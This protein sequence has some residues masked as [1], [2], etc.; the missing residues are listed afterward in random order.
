[1]EDKTLLSRKEKVANALPWLPVSCSSPSSWIKTPLWNLF[2]WKQSEDLH[3]RRIKLVKH[4]LFTKGET[5]EK[6]ALKG[7][8]LQC[9]A[10]FSLFFLLLL[11]ED[12]F[13]SH[14]SF[15][16]I[17]FPFYFPSLLSSLSRLWN[18]TSGHLTGQKKS[19]LKTVSANKPQ[20]NRDELKGLYRL[21]RQIKNKSICNGSDTHWFTLTKSNTANYVLC[22]GFIGLRS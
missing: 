6:R 21:F 4:S 13:I 10:C 11:S 15:L 12:Y 1:M 18:F 14:F 17:H 3:S 16:F 20:W 2:L 7:V 22:L 9:P 8:D 5:E 19:R